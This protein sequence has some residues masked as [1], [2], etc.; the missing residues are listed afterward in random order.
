M[1]KTFIDYITKF[2]LCGILVIIF[3]VLFN[4][5]KEPYSID[6]HEFH[7]KKEVREALEKT[8]RVGQSL[9]RDFMD[10]YVDNLKTPQQNTDVR[11][12]RNYYV[13]LPKEYSI[14]RYENNEDAKAASIKKNR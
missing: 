1:N 8:Q 11:T 9:D 7:S 4:I 6:S 14:V 10:D 2:S 5:L 12:K 13:P 3:L